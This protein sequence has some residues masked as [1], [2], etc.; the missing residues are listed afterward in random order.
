[1]RCYG[2]L[3]DIN[4]VRK[5][6]KVLCESLRRELEGEKSEPLPQTTALMRDFAV[7]C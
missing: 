1:M 3:G 6:Y 2:K 4:G 7:A 5:A